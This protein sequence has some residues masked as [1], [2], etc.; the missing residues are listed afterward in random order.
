[1]P[2]YE[3]ECTGCE[4][5]FDALRAMADADSPIACPGCGGEDIHRLISLFSA[6]GDEGVIV[7]AGPSCGSCAPSASCATCAAKSPR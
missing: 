4:T 5:R 7:G 1:M 6:V 3:Y 2:L